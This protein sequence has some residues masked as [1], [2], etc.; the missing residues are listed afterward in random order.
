MAFLSA[1]YC[2]FLSYTNS[3][4][5]FWL[6][7]CLGRKTKLTKCSFTCFMAFSLW[8]SHCYGSYFRTIS[9]PV[10]LN[11]RY[12]LHRD[13][14]FSLKFFESFMARKM[15]TFSFS[16]FLWKTSSYSC[17]CK[18]RWNQGKDYFGPAIEIDKNFGFSP[19]EMQKIVKIIEQHYKYLIQQ[20]YETFGK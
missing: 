10:S 20:W 19:P 13:M 6:T 15:L 18:E 7:S 17:S 5:N 11:L 3:K 2:F 8:H 12:A 9:L 4:R 1:I 14:R 16:L